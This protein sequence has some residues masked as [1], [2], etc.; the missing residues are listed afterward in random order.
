MTPEKDALAVRHGAE[1][2]ASLFPAL[3]IEAE[4]IAQTVASGL[5]GRRRAGP[6]ETFW[7]HRPYAFGDPVSSIDWRQS[8]RVADRLYI[9]QNEW[10]AAAAVYLWRDPSQSLNSRQRKRRRQNA[11]ALKSSQQQSQFCFHR[12]AKGLACLVKTVDRFRAA[13]HRPRILEALYAE[14]VDDMNSTPPVAQMPVGARVVLFSDFFAPLH[15]I[16]SAASAPGGRRRQG[17][18]PADLRSCRRGIPIPR[19]GGVS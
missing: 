15:E 2:A 10:E 17:R 7:Q 1:E 12:P 13:L 19:Q 4:R 3:L 6:G 14:Q 9:R 18:P 5:H 8:A 11:A 16:E